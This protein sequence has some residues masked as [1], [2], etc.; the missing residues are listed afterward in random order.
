MALLIDNVE[1]WFQPV[2]GSVLIVVLYLINIAG[3][4][5][6]V[7]L[8]FLILAILILAALDL[9][10]GLFISHDPSKILCSFVY[11]KVKV[12]SLFNFIHSR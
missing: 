11:R 3:V 4:K 10:F 12:K 9:A 1:P 2:I 6:V 8:Q 5:W 7:R